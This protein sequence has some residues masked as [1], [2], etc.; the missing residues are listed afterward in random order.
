MQELL[1]FVLLILAAYGIKYG[2]RIFE[3]MIRR[4][5]SSGLL[6]R[7]EHRIYTRINN[8]LLEILIG[9]HADRSY[10]FLFHNGDTMAQRISRKKVSCMFEQVSEGTS[11]EAEKLKNIDVT[12]IWDWLQ[13]FL[14]DKEKEL[15]KGCTALKNRVRCANCQST[16]R[17]L[18]FQVDE[19]KNGYLKA[20]LESQGVY[21]MVQCVVHDAQ[22]NII[23]ILGI[24]YC[25]DVDTHNFSQCDLCN[26]SSHL[27]L[28]LEELSKVKKTLWQYVK[29]LMEK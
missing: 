23:G 21:S 29:T 28:M 6:T 18:H 9:T 22:G 15:I 24:D 26:E 13:N 1:T 12:S 17:V 8:K 4:Q 10:L 14:V 3:N 16:R 20:L 2:K 11:A 25:S 7:E 27:T 5:A 19:L